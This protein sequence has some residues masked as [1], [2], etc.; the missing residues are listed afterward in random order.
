[1]APGQAFTMAPPERLFPTGVYTPIVPVPAFDVS[2]DGTR[3]L[4]LRETTAS[5]RNELIVVQNWTEEMRART[6]K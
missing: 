3:F 1:V 5:E 6:R 2:P 4:M